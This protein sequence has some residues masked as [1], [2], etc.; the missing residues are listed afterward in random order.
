MCFHVSLGICCKVGS[1]FAQRQLKESRSVVTAS[2]AVSMWLSSGCFLDSHCDPTSFLFQSSGKHDAASR[3][4]GRR[5]VNLASGCHVNT[6]TLHTPSVGISCGLLLCC[7]PVWLAT[8]TKVLPRVVAKPVIGRIG[9][10]SLAPRRIRNRGVARGG[11]QGVFIFQTPVSRDH[12]HITYLAMGKTDCIC[13]PNSII[14]KN[15]IILTHERM[16]YTH[17]FR[18]VTIREP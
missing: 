14:I 16:E 5:P 9:Y 11:W 13:S 7:S 15:N 1:S 3:H 17:V 8:T 2:L 10:G 18:P 4:V 6:W 12:L